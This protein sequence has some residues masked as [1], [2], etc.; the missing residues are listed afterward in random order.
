MHASLRGPHRPV[1][2]NLLRRSSASLRPLRGDNAGPMRPLAAMA[3]VAK[4]RL[5]S[6]LCAAKPM[7][8]PKPEPR[9]AVKAR[10][11]S[12]R[13]RSGLASHG[14]IRV[15]GVSRS[16]GSSIDP[17]VRPATSFRPDL[18]A[19]SAAARSGGQGWPVFGP[20]RQRRAASL[21]GASTAAGSLRSGDRS[22]PQA[23]PSQRVHLRSRSEP[24]SCDQV[25]FGARSTSHSAAVR[26]G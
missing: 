8:S 25:V 7:D 20:P 23:V 14:D 22:A 26:D 15:K 18:H 3:F 10:E 9:G 19:A 17:F 21:T 6:R 16:I 1:V 2:V 5:K 4:S 11:P 13:P 12:E 24:V